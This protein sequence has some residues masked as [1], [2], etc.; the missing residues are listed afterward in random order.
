MEH[1][2][3]QLNMFSL[4][5]LPPS[6]LTK[7][8]LK[9]LLLEIENHLAQYLKLQFDP[10]RRD[11]EVISHSYSYHILDKGIFLVI[12]S[13]P[14]LDNTNTFKIFNIF[15]MPVPVKDPVVPTDKLPSMVA[16]YRLQTSSIAVKLAEMKYVLLAATKQEHCT[17]PLW[18]CD[19]RSPVYSMNHRTL[20]TVALFLKDTENVKNYC[21]N[22]VEQNSIV[23]KAY[24]IIDG[25]WIIA[26]QN[27]LTFTAVC[28]QKQKETM[29]VN[30][31]LGIIKL[32]MS[33]TTTSSYLT[34]LAYY[35]NE[36]TLNIQDQ[37]I[38]N[39][40]S[41]NRS[42]FQIWEPFISTIPN[43]TR[44]QRFP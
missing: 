15:N 42:N 41:Y 37:F 44:H 3:L 38:D 26:S 9:V 17:S 4:G 27:T 13:I 33:C 19:A 20:C 14:L 32:N 10:K 22:E 30:P 11:L 35:H 39:L 2:Q 43:F 18:H 24:C 28:P 5:H 40:K 8:S 7:R 23:P 16:W 31:P 34:L 21:K 25:L 12:V 6:V 36:S 29:I 1:V